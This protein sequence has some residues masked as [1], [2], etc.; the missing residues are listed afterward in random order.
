MSAMVNVYRNRLGH[1]KKKIES[2][3]INNVPTKEDDGSTPCSGRNY[4]S[5]TQASP[6]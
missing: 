1:K 3:A 2:L 5:K 6:K 4:L